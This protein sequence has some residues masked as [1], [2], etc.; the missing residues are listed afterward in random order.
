MKSPDIGGAPTSAVAIG[1]FD[2]VHLG[3]VEI[4]KRARERSRSLGGRCVVVSFDP[5]PDLVLAPAGFRFPAPLTP[6]PE[7]RRRMLALGVDEPRVLPFTRELAAL[8]PEAFVDQHLME[9]LHPRVLVVGTGFALGRGRAGNVE[10]MRRMGLERGFEVDE[11]PLLHVDGEPVSS[12]RIR[13]ALTLGRVAEATRLLGRYYG[14]TGTVV[15]GHGIGR[16]LGY[17]TANLRLHEE[18]MLPGDG[19]YAA[20]VRLGGEALWRPAAMSIGVRPTF[21][22][23]LRQIEAFILDWSGQLVGSD[24]EVEMVDWLREEVRFESPEALVK[25][26]DK[27][28]AETRRRLMSAAMPIP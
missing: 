22:G 20:R 13:N 12:T 21:D 15:Q 18:Q 9:P 27:D 3:H 2:G 10:R 1:V 26:M 16:T 4:L 28:I 17:P 23:R 24:L 11:V 7:K 8:D 5:H 19:I 14:F 25:A 6:L